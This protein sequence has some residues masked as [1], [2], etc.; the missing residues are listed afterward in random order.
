MRKTEMP[1]VLLERDVYSIA[2]AAR[3][4]GLP[5]A[6]AKRWLDGYTYRKKAYRPVVRVEPTGS[7]IVTWAEF[8]ELGYLREYRAKEVS[9]Q[10]LRPAV[11]RLRAEFGAK[12]PLA[13]ARPFIDQSRELLLEIQ[14]E[15]K[16][17]R[18]LYMVV[19]RGGQ[20]VLTPPAE[21]FLDKVEFIGDGAAR[22][23]PAGAD[24]PVLIDPELSFGVPQ[25]KGVRT[26]AILELFLAKE[27]IELIADGYELDVGDVEAAIRFELENLAT[28]A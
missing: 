8:V 14:Q 1:A 16:L 12:Y 5:L 23:R 11:D 10:K 20:L 27:P 24:S 17:D 4:L 18:R 15:T 7:E 19:S 28:A 21:A 26:E 22:F 3:L 13:H 6:T 9:L 25:V 2:E